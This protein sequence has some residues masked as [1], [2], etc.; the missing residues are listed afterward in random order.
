MRLYTASSGSKP[1]ALALEFGIPQIQLL[2][3][4]GR[5][6]LL[7]ARQRCRFLS[8]VDFGVAPSTPLEGDGRAAFQ[9]QNRTEAADGAV[10]IIIIFLILFPFHAQQKQNRTDRQKGQ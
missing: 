1:L 4:E 6:A 10:V 7:R 5:P 8:T 2:R 3:Y 9:C